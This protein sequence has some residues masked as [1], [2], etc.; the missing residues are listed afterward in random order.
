MH[1]ILFLFLFLFFFIFR[2]RG[3]DIFFFLI[4]WIDIV[5]ESRDNDRSNDSIK[6]N[7]M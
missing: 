4:L 6:P 2:G 1:F 5:Y 7:Y 3:F